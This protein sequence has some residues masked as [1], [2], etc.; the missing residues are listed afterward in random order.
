VAGPL[1]PR[2]LPVLPKRV[3]PQDGWW[4][5]GA[6]LLVAKSEFTRV[7]GFDPRF[8]LYYEDQDLAR[9]Y[10]AA[11]LPVRSTRAVRARHQRGQSSTGEAAGA[12]VRQGWSYLSWIEYLFMWH[13]SA[14]AVRAARSARA[15]RALIDR[16]L[17][18]LERGGPLS[19]LAARKRSELAELEQFVRWQSSLGEGTAASDFCPNA[20]EIVA[21][22]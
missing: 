3:K 21:T 19:G 6:L 4:P 2:E 15:M 10:R 11:G 22:L 8:F 16:A 20:R 18:V 13:G 14:T 5:P 12:A 7:G 17:A 1:R 9:R